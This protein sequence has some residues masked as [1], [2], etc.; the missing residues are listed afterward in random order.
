[1][2][3]S[4]PVLIVTISQCLVLACSGGDEQR[5][6]AQL[7]QVESTIQRGSTTTIERVELRYAGSQLREVA[8]F[9]NGAPEGSAQLMY[10]ENGIAQIEYI[11][12]EGD[13]ATEQLAYANARLASARL[14]VPGVLVE[15]RTITYDP[16][17]GT[18]TEIATR[19]TVN[20]SSPTMRLVRYEYDPSG[21]TAKQLDIAGG[22]TATTELRYAEDG[23]IER[24]SMF[25]GGAHR[26]TYTFAYAD[27]RLHEVTDSR[28]GRHQITYDGSGRIAEIRWT[29]STGTTTHRYTY[30]D[31]NVDGWSF[32]PEVPVAQLFDLAGTA[33]DRVS[34]LHGS[35]AI[36]SDLP[37]AAGGGGG[38]GGGGTCSFEPQ[39]ACETCLAASCC[40]EAE[41]CLVGS[42]CD[43]YYQC[44]AACTT[45]D[46]VTLCGET[47]P[48]GRNAYNALVGCAQA[49]CPT[50]C[51]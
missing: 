15:E 43:N 12:P 14:E 39:T 21:R 3:A 16:R 30:A 38:G 36:P 5:S 10:G 31:G 40:S 26:E 34:L 51:S 50:A 35:I 23:R 7:V 29:T 1:M 25:E 19:T 4:V 6:H 42:P 41:A 33:Y 11:D 13:R 9:E 24:A 44:A 17:A 46:C 49:F 37:R 47:N 28:N 18:P 22:D 27:G 45:N 2:K 20:G 32:A 48:T 8:R